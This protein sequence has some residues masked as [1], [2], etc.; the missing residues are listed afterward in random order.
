MEKI[1]EYIGPFVGGIIF[2][3]GLALSGMTNPKKI[4]GFLDLFGN[5]DPTLV[6]VMV[7][8]LIV[9]IIINKFIS[10]RETPF[11]TKEFHIPTRK[12]IDAR[13][14]IGALIFGIGWA[15]TGLCP[16][17]ALTSIVTGKTYVYVFFISM[18]LGMSLVKFEHFFKR[19]K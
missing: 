8:A 14:I 2:A 17:P 6:F 9:H 19:K 10:K 11:F 5:W 4:S 15:I 16:G 13:L 18:L 1:K 3:I 12:D 7:G